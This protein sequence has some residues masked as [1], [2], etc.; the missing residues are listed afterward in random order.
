[1][2]RSRFAR[3]EEFKQKKLFKGKMWEKREGRRG[4]FKKNLS[5]SPG[6]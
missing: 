4:S 5:G 6:T 1:L 3:G 2:V